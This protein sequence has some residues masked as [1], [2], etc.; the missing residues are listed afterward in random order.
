MCQLVD[1]IL[2][3]P[4]AVLQPS[5]YVRMIYLLLR[6]CVCRGFVIFQCVP[7]ACELGIVALTLVH[8]FSLKHPGNAARDDFD[9]VQTRSSIGLVFVSLLTTLCSFTLTL[10]GASNT[11]AAARKALRRVSHI[12]KSLQNTDAQD[13]PRL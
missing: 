3:T 1:R 12:S 5:P 4:N 6:V 7:L 11:V 2:D 8:L 13:A 10:V 9:L